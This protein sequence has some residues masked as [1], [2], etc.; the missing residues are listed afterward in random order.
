MIS[1]QAVTLVVWSEGVCIGQPADLRLALGL[2]VKNMI[3]VYCELPGEKLAYLLA[4]PRGPSF[5]C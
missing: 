4:L 1:A 5:G 3:L 2:A